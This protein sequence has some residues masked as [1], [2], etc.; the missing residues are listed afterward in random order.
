[1]RGGGFSCRAFFGA[2]CLHFSAL[3]ENRLPLG[4]RGGCFSA[5]ALGLFYWKNKAKTLI[6]FVDKAAGLGIK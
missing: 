2:G 6:L 3:I 1:L 4:Q 5:F